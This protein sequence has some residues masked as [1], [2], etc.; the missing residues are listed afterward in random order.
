MYIFLGF[1]LIPP[2]GFFVPDASKISLK[3]KRFNNAVT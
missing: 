3:Q 1:I 2:I